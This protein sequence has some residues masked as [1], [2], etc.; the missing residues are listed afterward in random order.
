ML[1]GCQLELLELRGEGPKQGPKLSLADCAFLPG[2]Y[3][4][5]EQ[6]SQLHQP[7]TQ[8]SA[9]WTD[10]FTLSTVDLTDD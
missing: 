6:G 10:L 5:G 9:H 4:R 7:P 3:G 1:A 2:E 8:P